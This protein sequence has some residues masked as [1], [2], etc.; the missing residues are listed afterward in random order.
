MGNLVLYIHFS[1]DGNDKSSI[2]L[3]WSLLLRNAARGTAHIS[4]V[5]QFAI[6]AELDSF[7]GFR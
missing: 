6:G 4:R 1:E 5:Q 3:Y 2:D 7:W